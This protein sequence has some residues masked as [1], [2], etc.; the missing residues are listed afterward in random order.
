[1]KGEP[2]YN[3]GI[4]EIKRKGR[5]KKNWRPTTKA[6]GSFHHCNEN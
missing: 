3:D 1:M 5:L 2:L 4:K 6:L